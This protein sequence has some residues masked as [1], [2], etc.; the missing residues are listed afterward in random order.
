[1]SFLMT[2]P[3]WDWL[4]SFGQTVFWAVAVLGA[5]IFVH[6][7]G[8]HLAAK[9]LG[10]GVTTF[11]LGFGRKLWAFQRGETEYR[12]SLVP[13]G[14][15]V[16]LVGEDPEAGAE[17]PKEPGKS[18]HL[19]PVSHRLLVI[20]AGPAANILAALVLSWLLHMMGIPIPGTWVGG[21]LP[22][23]P[24]AAAG[25]RAGDHIAAIDGTPVR[26][27]G[28]LV[29]IVRG[30]AGQRLA[31]QVERS[32]RR[33]MLPITPTSK[34]EDGKE[35]GYGRIGISIGAG[36]VTERH[37][38]VDA[39]GQSVLQNYR[40]AHLTVVSL[41]AMIARIIP[42]DIGGPI[43]ISV[44]AAEQAQRGLRYLI[45]FTILL[46][47]NLA[48]LNLLPI[49]ILDGGHILFLLIEAL[50]GR[51]LSL[52]VRETAMQV[53]T[54]LLIA[55][56]IFATY[57]DSVYYLLRRDGEPAGQQEMKPPPRQQKPAPA[58]ER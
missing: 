33:L 34:G 58:G 42:A 10:I 57:K 50:R 18:F 26:K 52:R 4:L 8:H 36:I 7:L 25:L 12:V 40:I 5:L 6:E 20:A 56:M 48:I 21:V 31:L 39:M 55:L 29:E 9:K 54:V 13:L 47:V 19:R 24:A 28:D 49:P 44:V 16:K 30:K 43:R 23:S 38:P 32:G 15:Y 1:M 27:W 51:P 14:G 35:L 2:L 3:V 46:S 45:M 17:P 22:N 41:Y 11:S 53:G 37:G